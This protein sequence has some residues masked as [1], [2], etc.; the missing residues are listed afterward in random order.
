MNSGS[1]GQYRKAL[2]AVTCTDGYIGFGKNCDKNTK[3]AVAGVAKNVRHR[4][5]K[6][7][8]QNQ[9]VPIFLTE[10]YGDVNIS[11][12]PANE[13]LIVSPMTRFVLNLV[14]PTE[15]LLQRTLRMITVYCWRL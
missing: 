8:P 14:G 9:T 7:R 11:I 1:A 6:F 13:L 5:F 15:F 12:T 4:M 3:L 10:E 2:V